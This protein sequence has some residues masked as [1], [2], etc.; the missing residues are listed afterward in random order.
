MLIKNN[1]ILTLAHPN[2]I[3]SGLPP[4]AGRS[5]SPIRYIQFHK[6]INYMIQDYVKNYINAIN[7]PLPE[8]KVTFTAE[9]NFLRQY[10]KPN[11]T[12]LDVGCGAGR[13]AGA[14]ASLCKK[15]IGI[16]NDSKM[17]SEAK[18]RCSNIEIINGNALNMKFKDNTFDLVYT[19]Y[20]LVGC[21]KKSERQNLINEMK[22]VVK[23]TSKIINIVWKNDK[24]TTAF[25]SKYYPSIGIDIL[26]INEAKTITSTGVFERISRDELLGYYKAAGINE[27]KFLGVGP[28]WLA[29]IGSK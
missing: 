7:D 15:I 4:E 23:P 26:K 21:L 24:N 29:I 12:I 20:N 1:F 14:L 22:R 25:L 11:Y 2:P 17:L 13:P 27:I 28:V 16:D 9:F 3:L 6:H 19:T 5:D 18:K 10:I 8:M